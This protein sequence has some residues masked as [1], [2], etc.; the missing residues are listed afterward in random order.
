MRAFIVD[1]NVP[2]AANDVSAASPECV[3][4]AIDLLYEVQKG[5]IVLDDTQ[6]IYMEYKTYLDFD[7]RPQMPGKSFYLWVHE[8][9]FNPA[10]CE[11]ATITPHPNR[12]FTEFPEDEELQ[13]FD[14]ADRKFVALFF[15]SVNLPTIYNATDSDWVQLGSAFARLGIRITN[16]CPED[17]ANK[18]SKLSDR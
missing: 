15:K 13:E 17:L 9:Q 1:N 6:Q 14:K 10:K 5:M 12:G 4:S 2:M 16:I 7:P 11:Q 18:K 8:N 3:I